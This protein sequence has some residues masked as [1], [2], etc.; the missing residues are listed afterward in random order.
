MICVDAGLSGHFVLAAP[1]FACVLYFK[2]QKHISQQGGFLKGFPLTICLKRDAA[3]EGRNL[4]FFNQ[5]NKVIEEIAQDFSA[6]AVEQSAHCIIVFA[7]L[8]VPLVNG[9]EKDS[10]FK[11]ECCTMRVSGS[12]GNKLQCFV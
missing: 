6:A 12:W 2:Q 3:R 4:G 1:A 10:S 9:M 8:L 7:G 5:F 11:A